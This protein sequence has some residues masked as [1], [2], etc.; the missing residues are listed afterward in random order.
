MRLLG[1]LDLG[2]PL[3]GNYVFGEG[4]AGGCFREWR[5]VCYVMLYAT[6]SRAV[7]YVIYSGFETRPPWQQPPSSTTQ[8][9][10]PTK[11]Q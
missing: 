7:L 1:C 6:P 9:D 5:L 10:N 8:L 11:Q 4:I 2:F 3:G